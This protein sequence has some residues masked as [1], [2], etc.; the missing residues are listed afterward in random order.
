MEE[1]EDDY[2]I[3]I[4]DEIEYTEIDIEVTEEDIEEHIIQKQKE[5]EASKKVTGMGMSAEPT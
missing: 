3:E 5:K 2:N 4:D 1:V